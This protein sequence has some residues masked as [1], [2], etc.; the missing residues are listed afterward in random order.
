MKSINIMKCKVVKEREFEYGSVSCASEA[1]GIFRKLME[2]SAEEYFWMLCMD[3]KGKIVGCH[4]ISHGDLT[5]TAVHPREVFKRAILNNAAS[6]IVSHNHPSG[7][8]TPSMEDISLTARIS[9]AGKL[10]G[11]K[12]LD[13]IIIGDGEYHSF[14]GSGMLND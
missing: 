6:I 7:D 11:V 9:E 5:A 3:A 10:M 14:A 12:M 2:D 13:H 1:V 4:E 8:P